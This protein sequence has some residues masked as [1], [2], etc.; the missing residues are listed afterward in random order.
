MF[1]DERI[2]IAIVAFLIGVV[3]TFIIYPKPEIEEVYKFRTVTESDTVLIQ[4]IDT[5]YIPKKE[6]KTKVVR[7]TILID[8]KPNCQWYVQHL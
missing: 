6:I 4:D 8:H 1:D 3:L 7:D 5:V 2:R